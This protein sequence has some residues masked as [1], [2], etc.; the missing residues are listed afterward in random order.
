MEKINVIVEEKVDARTIVF[1]PETGKM[2]EFNDIESIIWDS[3]EKDSSEIAEKIQEIY[4]VDNK[5]L[6]DDIENF[7]VQLINAKLVKDKNTLLL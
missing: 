4:D 1:N 3:I 6:L 7:R 5:Q 2:Y